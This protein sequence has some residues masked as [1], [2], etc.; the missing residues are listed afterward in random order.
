MTLNQDD[1]AIPRASL[2]MHVRVFLINKG[3][4]LSQENQKD[5][6]VVAE[7]AAATG[8]TTGHV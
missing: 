2:M 1:V 7:V 6:D 8:T 5:Q 3:A 4:S